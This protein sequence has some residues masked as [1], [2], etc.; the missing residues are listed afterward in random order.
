ME[1]L[2]FMFI[3]ARKMMSWTVPFESEWYWLYSKWATEIVLSRCTS[4][5]IDG[6]MRWND[7]KT[8]SDE[9][10]ASITKQLDVYVQSSMRTL[11]LAI[12]DVGPDF[13][14]SQLEEGPSSVSNSDGTK[15]NSIETNFTFVALLGIEDPIRSEV[16]AIIQNC[17]TAGIDVRMV[18]GDSPNTT[19]SI[20]YQAGI[21]KRELY[22]N[23]HGGEMVASN[24]KDNVLLAGKSFRSAVYAK[25]DKGAFHLSDAC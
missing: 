20:A 17:Y 2:Q 12:C 1:S 13:D 8:M 5:L 9:T 16:L 19:V 7:A 11:A 18:T 23:D 4:I 25:G 15:A 21:L 22:F 24:L 14:L 10:R 6:P 3:S